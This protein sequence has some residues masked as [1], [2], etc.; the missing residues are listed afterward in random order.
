[1]A[2]ERPLAIFLPTLGG[3][4]AERVMVTLANTLAETSYAVDLVLAQAI[5][6]YLSDVGSTVN[7][8]DLRA[9]S[10]IKS[11]IPLARY[12]RN[13]RPIALL[14][15]LD[16]ANVVAILAKFMSRA[17][18]R[19]VIRL[20]NVLTTSI[21]RTPSKNRVLLAPLVRHLYR[22]ADK[23]VAVSRGVA[24]DAIAYARLTPSQVVTINNPVVTD[25]VQRI[26]REP[27]NDP[28][29]TIGAP[30]VVLGVGRLT[31]QKDFSTLIR[32]FAEVRKQ[33]DAR[34]IILGEGEERARL[35]SLI[36]ELKLEPYVRLP[37]FVSNPYVYMARSAVF[38]LSSQW[39]GFPNVL[40]E[41]LAAGVPV[42]ATD[43]LAGPADILEDGRYGKL[44]PVGDVSAMADAILETLREKTISRSVL[45][46]RA[47]EFSPA[48]IVQRYLEVL[49][50]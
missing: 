2:K 8:V 15:T 43:C 10:T 33:E 26:A 19:V 13:R 48:E 12:L 14:S 42:V 5:G 36:S 44:V 28:W 34:L 20:A 35:Q 18:T 30:P 47:G 32:A 46:A 37:G 6:P 38:V 31:T 41:A 39:E 21:A 49:L 11:L 1:M 22:H 16:R 3:G 27:I 9:G 17:E 45:Q 29:L 23:V 7:L 50:E 40:L 4:G 25:H 24:T